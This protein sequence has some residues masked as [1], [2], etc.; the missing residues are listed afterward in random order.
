MASRNLHAQPF[1]ESTISKLEI[2]EKYAQAWIPTFIMGKYNK[3]L[4]FDFF[5]GTGY[6]KNGVE[7]SS[8]RI[9]N[10]VLE[11]LSNIQKHNI[12]VELHFNE[13][14]PDNLTQTKFKQLETACEEYFNIH[15]ELKKVSSL[16]LYNEDF[17]TNFKRLLPIIGTHPS[18]VYLDQNGIKFLS[19]DYLL[20]LEKMRQT[21]FLYFVSSSY[22]WRFGDTPEFKT[23]LDIDMESAKKNGFTMIHRTIVDELRKKISSQ[24]EL[25]LYPFSLQKDKNIYGIIFGAKHP[26]AVDKFLSIAWKK[27]ELNGEANFDI[28]NDGH[29]PAVIQQSLFESY[30]PKRTKI[31]S[32]QDNVKNKI[33]KKEI[34]DN[35]ALLKFVHEEGHIGAHAAECLKKMKTDGLINYDGLSP[36]VT[37]ENVYQKKNIIQYKVI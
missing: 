5:A 2:F 35:L 32:F 8:I 29:A 7:G 13:W 16:N 18:L 31:E 36:Y 17:S 19:D 26:R 14:E 6:D 15:P 25:K 28:Y 3:I 10:K 9:L 33:L 21:D 12:T 20:E 22:V 4:I 34:C 24:S 1:D 37:Y 23:H 27:N 11:Q 30:V